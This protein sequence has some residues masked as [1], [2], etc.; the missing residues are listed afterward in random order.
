MNSSNLNN[1]LSLVS[2]LPGYNVSQSSVSR[3]LNGPQMAVDNDENTCSV[4]QKGVKEF[5]RIKFTQTLTVKGMFLRLKGRKGFLL[6][7]I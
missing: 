2:S 3:A 7:Y 6:L 5:W 1:T 4:T